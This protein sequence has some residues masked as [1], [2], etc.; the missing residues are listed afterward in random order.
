LQN[1]QK[2]QTAEASAEPEAFQAQQ[3]EPLQ[4]AA[5]HK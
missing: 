2:I 3:E 4:S 1:P 5:V